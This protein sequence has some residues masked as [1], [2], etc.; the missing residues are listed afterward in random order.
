MTGI[1]VRTTKFA[2]WFDPDAW[3]ESMRGPKWED[4]LTEEASNANTYVK[5][6][7]IQ[8]RAEQCLTEYKATSHLQPS[9]PFY[10]GVYTIQWHNSFFKTWK[11]LGSKETHTARAVLPTDHGIYCVE[12]VGKGAEEFQLQYWSDP[13]SSKPTWTKGSVGPDIGLLGNTLFYL[14]VENKLIYHKLY[15]CHAKTGKNETCI[16]TEKNP[17]TNL[18]IEVHP[19]G[20]VVVS[21]ETS[22]SFKYYQLYESGKL[23]EIPNPKHIPSTWIQPLMKQHGIDWVCAC[24]RV[25]LG[26]EIDA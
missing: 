15:M 5:S 6:H 17:E 14:G 8:K 21:A 13:F 26:V 2:S 23:S 4:I 10:Y 16:Y 7:Q 22:Q 25:V 20:Q 9:M 1:P 24:V 11:V 3:M 18:A 12:D 19:D